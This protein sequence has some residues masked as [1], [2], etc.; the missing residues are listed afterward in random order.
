MQLAMFAPDWTIANIRVLAKAIPGVAKSKRIARL[1]QYYAARGAAFFATA[2]SAVNIMYTGKPIWMNEDPT[3]I[4]MGDGRKMTFSKQFV[5]PAHWATDWGKTAINK[6]GLLPKT[7]I[8]QAQG[9][10]YLSGSGMSP[11]MFPEE[12]ELGERTAARAKHIG[13]KF[14]P[15]F[16]QQVYD[17]GTSGIAGFLGHPI[18]GKKQE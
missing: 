6:M 13:K 16:A 10:D 15:I 18:Y 17:Q 9:I 8:E 4:D 3:T 2:G 7:F 11:K 1:H 14:T 12:A 5:E